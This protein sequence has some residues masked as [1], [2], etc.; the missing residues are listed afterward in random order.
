MSLGARKRKVS[1]AH[2]LQREI[3]AG[4]KIHQVFQDWIA[5]FDSKAA[6]I[7]TLDSAALAA[8]WV[9][10]GPGRTFGALDGTN[11]QN[12]FAVGLVSLAAG[13]ICAA[14]V[15]L[16]RV[17]GGGL[18][19]PTRLLYFGSVRHLDGSSVADALSDADLKTELGHA[20]SAL[21]KIAW[22]KQA[23]VTASLWA[24]IA[25]VVMLCIAA[26]MV[27]STN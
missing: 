16:P 14:S 23:L 6:A 2:A 4:W 19:Q 24:T 1:D 18:S 12:P 17:H 8:V 15:V 3:E 13:A 21:A 7:V 27:Y 10:S 9:L 20:I 11:A 22:R 26:A 25:G 5:R